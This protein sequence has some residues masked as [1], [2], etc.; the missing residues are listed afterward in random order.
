MKNLTSY[1]NHSK[2]LSESYMSNESSC[3]SEAAKEAVKKVCEEVLCKEADNY[4]NDSNEGHTYEGYVNECMGY[5][6][7]AMGHS[8]YS[9]L[10]KSFAK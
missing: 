7:E 1:E 2:G 4:H 5:M 8:G 9:S 10:H 3:M 6:R